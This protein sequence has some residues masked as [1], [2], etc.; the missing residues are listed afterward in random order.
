[1]SPLSEMWICTDSWHQNHKS[2]QGIYW[3]LFNVFSLLLHFWTTNVWNASWI[4]QHIYTS[5]P[6]DCLFLNDISFLMKIGTPLLINSH[7]LPIFK[8]EDAKNYDSHF[9]YFQ[10]A[11]Y[12]QYVVFTVNQYKSTALQWFWTASKMMKFLKILVFGCIIVG[13]NRF[14]IRY[15]AVMDRKP[16]GSDDGAEPFSCLIHRRNW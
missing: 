8:S 13:T 3:I 2:V 12:C 11:I 1:M 7:P 15:T 10:N 6:W 4:L 5:L 16:V 9:V 14:S